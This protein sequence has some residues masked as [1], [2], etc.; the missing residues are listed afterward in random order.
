[1]RLNGRQFARYSRHLLMDDI[2]VDGQHRLFNSHVLV[3][4]MGGLG[5]PVTLY[6]AAAGIGRLSICDADIVAESNLHRQILYR[7]ADCGRLKVDCARRALKDVNPDLMV[8]TH[9]EPVSAEILSGDYRLVLDCSDNL[10]ARSL[11][12]HH[13]RARRLPLISASATGWEGQLMAFD[14]EREQ[15][16]C[17]N[18]S[19][20][21]SSPEGRADCDTQG[22]VGPVLGVIGSQ[23]ATMA[24]AMLLGY[25]HPHGQLQRYDGKAGQWM[26][27]KLQA[28][29][30]CDLCAPFRRC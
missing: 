29:P 2:G 16:P 4:G 20:D 5:C 28:N 13:C 30:N 18:C 27:F 15:S 7:D 1:M 8:D 3:V 10:A 9:A 26:N 11:L 25:G 19:I 6:L 24:M 14:F 21:P 17:F 22:V 23:Q 12:N